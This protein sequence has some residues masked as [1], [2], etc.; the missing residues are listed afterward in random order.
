MAEA[1]QSR[2]SGNGSFKVLLRFLPMLWPKG[3][4][5]LKARVI[6][7]V[8]LHGVTATHAM[9]RLDARRGRTSAQD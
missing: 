6:A 3:E 2:T 4:A 9:S 1:E 5:E 8:L 7:S